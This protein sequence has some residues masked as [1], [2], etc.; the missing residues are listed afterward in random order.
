MP[1]EDSSA[2]E[3]SDIFGIDRIETFEVDNH[4]VLAG[5]DRLC[6]CHSQEWLGTDVELP[7]AP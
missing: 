7:T 4:L 2:N 1:E 6:K 3:Q 5:G